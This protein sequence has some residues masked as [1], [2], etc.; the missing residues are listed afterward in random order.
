MNFF[1]YVSYSCLNLIITRFNFHANDNVVKI[2][3]T[4]HVLNLGVC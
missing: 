4:K 2:L 3:I 1:F